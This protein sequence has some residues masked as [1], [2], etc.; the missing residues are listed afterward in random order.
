MDT[1]ISG[2]ILAGFVV[3]IVLVVGIW[4][5]LDITRQ[6]KKNERSVDAGRDDK[7]A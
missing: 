6:R 1:I 2:L 5:Q 3:F 4:T 7:A